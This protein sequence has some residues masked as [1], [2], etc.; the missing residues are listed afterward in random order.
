M[1]DEENISTLAEYRLADKN[2]KLLSL[3]ADDNNQRH[4]GGDSKWQ[5]CPF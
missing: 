2:V 5:L 1:E 3:F 4:A